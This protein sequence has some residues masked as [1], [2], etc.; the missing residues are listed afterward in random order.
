MNKPSIAELL[1]ASG[2]TTFTP[3][4]IGRAVDTLYG[5]IGAGLDERDWDTILA[6]DDPLAAA[7]AGLVA[8]YSDKDFLLRN[9]NHLSANY[10]A[11]QIEYTYR[12][13]AD[14]LE[15]SHSPE[16]ATGT[17]YESVAELDDSDVSSQ[18]RRDQEQ[19][20][21]ND[22]GGGGAGVIQITAQN[23]N[24]STTTDVNATASTTN[25]DDTIET[26]FTFLTGT[27]IDGGGGDDTLQVTDGGTFSINNNITNILTLDLTQAAASSSVSGNVQAFENVNLS[28]AGDTVTITGQQTVFINGGTGDDTVIYESFTAFAGSP[29]DNPANMNDNLTDQGGTDTVQVNDAISVRDDLSLIRAGGFERLVQN[30]AGA[31]DF[32]LDTARADI[33][34]IDVSAS[35]ANSTV[36]ASRPA[37]GMT[38]WS[39]V[40]VMTASRAAREPIR[41]PAVRARTS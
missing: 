34:V 18:A 33:N 28:N 16:W 24:V 27:T 6:S 25:G 9:A 8:M 7:E 26:Q 36:D 4:L 5:N 35:T 1:I 21:E 22:N 39:V 19:R 40:V 29:L 2:N 32:K 10:G 41:S 14:R 20:Q 31:A 23:A 3:D 38:P 17:R 13:I 37:P 12:Q 15:F 30:D 11:A